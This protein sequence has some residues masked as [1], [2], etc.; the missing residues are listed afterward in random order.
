MKPKLQQDVSVNAEYYTLFEKAGVPNDEKW[1][2]T[3][4]FMRN[5]AYHDFLTE[6][7]K[8]QMQDILVETIKEQKFSETNY[9]Q[10]IE[11]HKKIISEPFQK[12]IEETIHETS[13]LL[14]ELKA[15]LIRRKGDVEKLECFAVESI[16]KEKEP[17]EL[18]IKLRTAFHE[19]TSGME[20][21]AV[22]LMRMSI[23]DGLTGLHNR[24]ALDDYLARS[25]P[26]MIKDNTTLSFI[27]LDIDH[28]KNFNDTHGHLIGDQA[29]TTVAKNLSNCFSQLQVET[30]IDSFVA[31]YGGEEFAVVM[32]SVMLKDAF[33]AA[34]IVRKKVEGYNFIIRDGE[35]KIESSDIHLTVSIG[36][37]SLNANWLHPIEQLVEKADQALYAA[38]SN[39]R[40]KVICAEE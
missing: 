14:N 9:K 28:F 27:L 38:K 1:R 24:R 7:Q 3:I 8:K 15:L 29:L 22:N 39:G 18:I 20:E 10:I 19:V 26:E 37:A 13:K 21:D 31:R 34:E 4:L 16:E 40:N 5:I 6:K 17:K 25:V 2:T 32:P 30:N 36:V 12:K 35:G 23:T 33:S 11:Q